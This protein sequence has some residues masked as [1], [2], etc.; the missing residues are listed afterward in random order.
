MPKAV[1]T[2]NE[3]MCELCKMKLR[4]NYKICLVEIICQYFALPDFDIT[5]FAP[6][7]L[8]I[9]E[10]KINKSTGLAKV[11]IQWFPPIFQVEQV[12][13]QPFISLESVIASNSLV[14]EVGVCYFFDFLTKKFCMLFLQ[15]FF[16]F[17]LA[18][19]LSCHSGMF[20]SLAISHSKEKM[21]QLAFDSATFIFCIHK[22]DLRQ[23]HSRKHC[24]F[25][26][27]TEAALSGYL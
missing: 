2:T 3:T 26:V 18:H 24:K 11:T 25:L 12:L 7:L 1:N 13:F 27:T 8:Q 17:G 14:P 22:V 16:K 15:K 20:A 21:K 6:L 4:K 9:S 23:R 19:L 10:V 5:N